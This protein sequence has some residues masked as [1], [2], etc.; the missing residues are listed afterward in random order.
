[1]RLSDFITQ[2]SRL[3]PPSSEVQL[4]SC[5]FTCY[6]YFSLADI[7]Y[8]PTRVYSPRPQQFNGPLT[9]ALFIL[10]IKSIVQLCRCY[11]I[12]TKIRNMKYPKTQN[13]VDC[14]GAYD[15][16]KMETFWKHV[17][18]GKKCEFQGKIRGKSGEKNVKN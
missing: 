8:T 10:H 16:S 13:F 2:Y 18:M 15:S 4:V 3:F 6:Y 11:A 7:K 12:P 17:S 5:I 14:K 9:Q 1:M